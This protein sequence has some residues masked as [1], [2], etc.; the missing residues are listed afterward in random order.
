[1]SDR[2]YARRTFHYGEGNGTL[3]DR[4]Q[5]V[6]L[7]GSRNDEK[8]IRL[9]YVMPLSKRTKTTQ[10]GRCGG[11]FVSDETLNSHGRERHPDRSLS[12]AEIERLA[13]SRAEREDKISP[14]RLDQTA[15]SRG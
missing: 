1:M 6:D 12:P 7:C 9:G 14:L 4:G 2:Y 10:C 5:V 13:E 15:A 11:E 8:L 3:H